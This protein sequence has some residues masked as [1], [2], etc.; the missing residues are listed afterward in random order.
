MIENFFIPNKKNN[1]KAY[2]IRKTAIVFYSFILIFV[3]SFGGFLGISQ[4][5]ASTITPGNIIN[6][7]NQE[8]VAWGLNA[9]QTNSQLSAAALAKA[10]D[11]FEKQYWDHFGPNGESPWQFIRAAGY[12]YVY[13]GENLAKG[14]RTA[15][16]V[17]EAW[18]AS[19]THKANIISG[20]YKDIGVAVVEGV[21]LG[22][23]TILV[24][25]MFGNLTTEVYGA[26]PQQPA[27][28]TVLPQQEAPPVEEKKVIT[29]QE[30]GEIKSIRITS[31][32]EG[33]VVTDPAQKVQGDTSNVSGN[34][35]VEVYDGQDLLGESSS[36]NTSWEFSKNGDWS[37]GEHTVMAN[38]KGDNIQSGRVNFIVDSKAPSVNMESIAVNRINGKYSVMFSIEGEWDTLSLVL[39]SEIINIEYVESEEG[40]LIELTEEQVKGSVIIVLSDEYGNTS[41]L[42]I[43]EYFLEDESKQRIIF[44]TIRLNTG[45]KI[46]IGIVSFI[47]ILLLIEVVVYWKKGNI[48]DV[49]NDIFVVGAWWLIL[50]IAL[51]NGF[52]GIIN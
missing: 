44:P 48:K 4:A 31:P 39:G 32:Q 8:R 37:E 11:M 52:S 30:S 46:S 49:I 47:F 6:L 28:E 10:N 25:Q 17:H 51:F 43:S 21:L 2:L 23:Q 20:N 40:I 45:D 38:L 34:Y 24:V 1:Y 15:E 9:L 22:K 13:A 7:T 36:S 27:E 19:P 33:S 35:I 16:G 14:F 41:E 29:R 3:N 26:T 5:Q 42:D 12:N 50:T 18:M